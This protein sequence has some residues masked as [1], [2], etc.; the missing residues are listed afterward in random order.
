MTTWAQNY[1][2]TGIV[3]LSTILAALPVATLLV[4]IVFLKMRIHRAALVALA[5]AAVIATCA[6]GMPV[7]M[8]A[9]SAV[10][11]AVYGLFPIGWIILNVIFLYQLT[12]QKGHFDA[13]RESLAS[14]APDPRIQLILI[15]FAFGSFLEGVAGFG[16]P[17][18]IT[19]AILVQ[20]R[21]KPLEACALALIANTA[22]VAFGAVGIPILTLE[23]VAGLDSQPGQHDGG[24]AAADL[25]GPDPLLDR[26]DFRRLAGH[27]G[28]L[29]R[30]PHGR[31]RL[32][33]AAIPRFQLPR[34]LACRRHF[35]HFFDRGDDHPP[36]V[37]EAKGPLAHGRLGGR[38]RHPAG[39]QPRRTLARLAP[40]GHPDGSHLCLGDTL[41]GERPR[42]NLFS[43]VPG[44]HLHHLVQRMP[45]VVP[46]GAKPEA[47]VFQAEPA[48]GHGFRNT[49]GGIGGRIHDGLF[50]APDA[51]LST[52]RPSGISA[53]AVTIAAMLALGN[54]TKYSGTDA[55]MGLAL[56]HTGRLYP[57]FGTLLGWLGVAMTGSDTSSN[58]LF[59]NL[60][61][62]T[63]RQAGISPILMG[64]ANSSGGVMGK[65]LSAQSI[66]VATTAT[67][68]YGEEGRIIR[69]SS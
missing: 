15:A 3:A 1:N 41:G 45:P 14:I 20:L 53:C 23:Q 48:F 67:N 2:P 62:I 19:A 63:A 36:A 7:D 26:G 50:P 9:A 49:A 65:M 69:W 6:F 38:G 39:P 60:Q 51:G 10:Y 13:L 37:L 30:R 56:A 35:K 25:F 22:P 28:H 8:A 33:R 34:P 18:A 57:F 47:A 44:P 32:C 40:L 4:M 58:V 59:G 16:A 66:V 24:P 43:P 52:A 68:F 27:A 17:V 21:F 54:L 5:L 12:V 11:G 46:A 31:T 61:A 55:T 29:A 64:A 42:P